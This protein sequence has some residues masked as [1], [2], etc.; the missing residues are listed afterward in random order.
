MRYVCL[1]V[2]MM[3][4]L[5]AQ[6][7]AAIYKERCA[8]CHD[9]PAARVPS[10]AAIKAMSPE[11][12]YIALS[13]GVMKSRA[14][15]LSTP[16][17]FSLIGYIAPTGGQHADTSA[18]FTPTCKSKADLQF[19]ANSPQWN[20]WSPSVTNSRFQDAASAGLPLSEVPKLKLKWAFNL[21]DTTVARTQPAIVGGRM[22]ITTASGA[23]FALDADTGC[24]RWGFK[25][26]GGIR[27]GVT[28]GEANGAPA[29]FFGD[30]GATMYAVNAQTGEL[31][32]KLRPVD[33]FATTATAAPRYYKGVLYQP[34]ASFEEA[35]GPDPKF[36]CCTFRGSVVALDAGTGKKLWQTFTI[37]ETPKPTSKNAAGTQQ[38]GPSGA[39]VWSSPTIDE[40][41]G[42][43]YVATGDNYSDPATSTSDAILAMDLKSGELLWSRQLTE[44]DAFNTGCSTPQRTNCPA[45]AGPD[46]DFGQPPILVNLG[47]GKRALVIGQKSGMVHAIDPDQKGKILWQTRAGEGSALGG[48]Q[49]GSA[50][51]GRN[52]YVAI[53]DP[54]IGG[55]ADPKSPLGFRLTLDP[56]KG[57]G[58]HALDLKT[59]KIV[60]S[61]EP[62][63][64][65][66]GRTD[67]SPAQSAAVSAISG[68]IFSGSVDGHLRAYSAETGEVLWDT[69]TSREFDTV[70]GKPAHGGSLD[71]AGP[72]IVNGMVFVNS[73]YGQWGGMPGNVLLAFSVNGR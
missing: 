50:S 44:N 23:V 17:I 2:L 31:I 7:G 5:S 37:A 15:G 38:F 53:S 25:A 61:A 29:I 13:S 54:G 28:F 56:K 45:K 8:S 6:D 41:L 18:A 67:C 57:G 42:V 9:M 64:C 52:I 73:G 14:E 11:A 10:L 55:V 49:W 46:F 72:A 66:A 32:W 62:T 70:N 30:G 1:F 22:F 3:P 60:W 63:P 33:H 48:S 65:A 39:S 16:E 68:A 20:G 58:L 4:M 51:D 26:A 19:S 69:D 27:S 35:L 43:L 47:G 34:F 40:Q 36:G 12:I 21:G 71:A 24:T 59:G